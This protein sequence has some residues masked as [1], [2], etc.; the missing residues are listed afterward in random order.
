MSTRE[1]LCFGIVCLEERLVEMK[2]E[3]L[4]LDEAEE[5]KCGTAICCTDPDC[6]G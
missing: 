4:A 6:N 2:A 3:L 5:R 1:S